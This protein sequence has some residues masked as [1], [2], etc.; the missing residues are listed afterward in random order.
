MWSAEADKA[1]VA[2]QEQEDQ[3]EG[4]VIAEYHVE[5]HTSTLRGGTAPGRVTIELHGQEGSREEQQLTPPHP[6]AFD[7]GQVRT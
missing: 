5:V 2:V 7:R 3:S 4:P 6:R 1:E